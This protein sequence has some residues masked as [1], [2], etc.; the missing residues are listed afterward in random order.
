M[1]GLLVLAWSRV[2]EAVPVG[3]APGYS[4]VGLAFYDNVSPRMVVGRGGARPYPC[5]V[6]VG[7]QWNASQ[8]LSVHPISVSNERKL[9]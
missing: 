9:A 1:L 4:A 8:V 5:W 7:M 6:S 2:G 3:Q